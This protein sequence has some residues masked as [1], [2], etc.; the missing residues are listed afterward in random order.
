MESSLPLWIIL[1]LSIL[2]F[3][4]PASIRGQDYDDTPDSPPPMPPEEEDCNGVFITYTFISRI[5]E[6]PH[7]KNASA[8]AYAFKAQ[9]TVTNTM[10]KDLKQWKLYVGFQHKE[11]LVSVDGAVIAEGTDFPCPVGN[12]TTFAGFPQADLA[13]SI[14]TAGDMTKIQVQIKLL[15]TQFGVKPTGIPMPKTIKIVHDGIKCPAPKR[16]G[17]KKALNFKC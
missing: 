12:G 5:K 14:D 6:F 10:D 13:N 11:I 4:S 2:L 8:Q 9:A 15:G 16:R 1:L 3:S 7:V 17:K